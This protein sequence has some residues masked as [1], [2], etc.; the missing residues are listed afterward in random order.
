MAAR[1]ELK[2][3]MADKIVVGDAGNGRHRR[4]GDGVRR[5]GTLTVLAAGLVGF[6]GGLLV[7]RWIRWI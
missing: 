5:Y 7:R 4:P 3:A 6:I 2:D 1:R